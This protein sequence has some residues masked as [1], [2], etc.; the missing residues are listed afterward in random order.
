MNYANPQQTTGN[1]KGSI[2]CST[3]DKDATKRAKQS[4]ARRLDARRTQEHR[5][6]TY[7]A[8]LSS[9]LNIKSLK[10][11]IL[12]NE[13]IRRNPISIFWIL[14]TYKIPDVEP[15]AC[16]VWVLQVQPDIIV[17]KHHVQ[18]PV[19]QLWTTSWRR[20][21]HLGAAKK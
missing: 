13:N 8:T 17:I 9:L 20:A 11:F 1:N 16:W 21:V 4:V 19:G 2:M 10:T 14:T 3:K 18:R 5:H 15:D 6:C 12:S 7:S